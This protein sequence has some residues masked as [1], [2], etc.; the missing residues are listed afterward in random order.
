MPSKKCETGTENKCLSYTYPV[1]T[2]TKE[3]KDGWKNYDIPTCRIQDEQATHC[4]QLPVKEIC[5]DQTITRQIKIPTTKCDR[6]STQ[7]KCLQF[8]E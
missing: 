6:Q 7:R 1:T 4:A 5:Q 2:V 3:L 8:P